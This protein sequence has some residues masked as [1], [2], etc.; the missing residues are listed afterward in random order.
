MHL[1][2]IV[3]DGFKSYAT[4]TTIG[5]LHK[6]FNAISGLNGTGKSNILDAICFVMGIKSLQQIAIGGRDRFIMN[7]HIARASDVASVL[8][9]AQLNVNNPHFLVMQLQDIENVLEKEIQPNLTQM[10]QKQY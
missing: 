10:R 7:G 8:Q 6:Q 2:E 3:I 1:E 4:K 5:L 9:S